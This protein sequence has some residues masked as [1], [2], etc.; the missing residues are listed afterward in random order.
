V[1]AIKLADNPFD[2]HN[3]NESQYKERTDT[4][5]DAAR[6]LASHTL[7]V[8]AART[9]SHPALTVPQMLAESP[10]WLLHLL[11]WV[12]VPGGVYQINRRRI[13]LRQSDRIVAH[14][15]GENGRLDPEALRALSLLRS[16]DPA[17]LI[18]IASL[19]VEERH[20]ANVDL[21]NEGD[22]GQKFYVI[23]RGK[24]EITTT[25]A[26]GENLRLAL[27]GDGDF[28]GE[29]ALL[30]DWQH[31]TTARTLIP[32]VFLSL[33]RAR[34]T[35]LLESSAELRASVE[36]LVRAREEAGPRH[37][38]YGEAGIEIASYHEGEE[39]ELARTFVDYDDSPRQVQLQTIQS[40]IRL[41]TRITDLYNNVYEQLREQLRH[42]GYQGARGIGDHQRPGTRLVASG[43]PLDA[44]SHP[45]RSSHH[46]R[47]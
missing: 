23:A 45:V 24:V 18:A 13:V 28:F 14:F 27:Y 21:Y 30:N 31:T 5:A 8:R 38:E 20:P 29:T 1:S 9:L 10:R 26:H 46:G 12:N 2:R 39:P 22:A 3:Y 40:V 11:P 34:F 19:L 25:D 7:S 15:E 33:E 36:Q 17:V 41:H 37:N 32:S 43:R 6:P 42:P 47:S 35:V 16:A 4:M 44:H